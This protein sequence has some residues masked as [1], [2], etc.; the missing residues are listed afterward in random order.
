MVF[1]HGFSTAR[2]EHH[3]LDEP[4]ELSIDDLC[5]LKDVVP[6][7]MGIEGRLPI[8]PI[9]A[10]VV[11]GVRYPMGYKVCRVGEDGAL[12]SLGLKGNPTPLRYEIGVWQG[13]ENLAGIRPMAGPQDEGGI[14]VSRTPGNARGLAKYAS[15]RHGMNVRAFK[16]ACKERRHHKAGGMKTAPL[17][18]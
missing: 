10:A 18:I 7:L 3:I 13:L 16:T 2:H 15:E 1:L 17:L 4:L 11:E 9:H 14:H 12:Y 8:P 5:R 6:G